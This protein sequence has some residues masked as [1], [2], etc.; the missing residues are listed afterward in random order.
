MDNR[1]SKYISLFALL[2]LATQSE[3][4]PQAT[5]RAE[6]IGTYFNEDKVLLE[7]NLISKDGKEGAII[8]ISPGR[9]DRALITEGQTKLYIPSNQMA[10][11]RL[12]FTMATPTPKSAP[13]F[14]EKK[15]RTFYF[16][17]LGGKVSLVK[18][19]ALT[20]DER[21]RLKAAI[22]ELKRAGV[23]NNWKT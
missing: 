21:K 5:T 7:L 4:H 10:K 3:A 23:Y 13:E 12:L 15:T 17:I 18:P 14:F 19:Q 20:L 1:F 16:R 2:V 6:V 22:R 8:P 9:I 11:R